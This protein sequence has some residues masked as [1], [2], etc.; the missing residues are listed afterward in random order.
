MS[1]ICMILK[2]GENLSSSWMESLVHFLKSATSSIV[3]NE[4][5][6]KFSIYALLFILLI[7][8]L[9]AVCLLVFLMS[10]CYVKSLTISD[11]GII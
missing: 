4:I 6:A 10:S 2:T 8:F 7:Y 5:V 9:T 3:K 11:E 1:S